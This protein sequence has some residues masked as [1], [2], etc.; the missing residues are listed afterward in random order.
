M[1]ARA[2]VMVAAGLALGGA[3]FLAAR[4]ANDA[5]LVPPAASRRQP[6][7][8]SPSPSSPTAP[9]PLP[10]RLEPLA[11]EIDSLRRSSRFDRGRAAR[12]ESHRGAR[13]RVG[14]FIS[15]LAHHHH[16]VALAWKLAGEP[17][18][19]LEAAASALEI[20]PR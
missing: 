14:S 13:D 8:S 11:A 4:R 6:T 9:R 10:G 12:R 19:A 18:K 5:S 15:E 16:D 7:P 2:A 20:W 17:G 3:V 1:T